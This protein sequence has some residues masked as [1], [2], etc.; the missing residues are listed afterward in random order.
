MLEFSGIFKQ[1]PEGTIALDDMNFALTSGEFV[2]I[3]GPSGSGKTTLLHLA[4]GLQQPTRGTV[5]LG[6]E[7]IGYVFQHPALL[8]WRTV[9]RNIELLA[10]LRD[11]RSY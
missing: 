11:H 7:R 3:V 9:R 1:F 8:P 5:R 4:T 2:S 6:T 10:E